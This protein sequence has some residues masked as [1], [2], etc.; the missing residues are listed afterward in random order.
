VE[1]DGSLEPDDPN[2][3][4]L[5]FVSPPL[6]IDEILGDLNKV[7]KWAKEYGCYTNDSTGLHINISVP[8]YSRENLDFVKLALLMGDKY[9]LD[10]FGRSGNTYAKSALDIVKRAVRDNP[11]NAAQL[12]DKMKGNLDQLASKAIHSGITSKYTSINTKDGH[13]EF[14]SPGG[15]WLGDNFDQIENTL[16]RFTVA[17][18][19]ALNP[20]MYRQ[21]YLTKLY[22]MLTENN[23]DDDTIKYFSDY[24]AGKIPKAALRSFVKQAQL[25]RNIKRGKTDGQKM[26]WKVY[27][28][29]KNAGRYSATV[30]VVAT[31]EKEAIEKAAKEW[32]EPLLVNTLARMD[33]EPLRPYVEQPGGGTYELFDR[34]TNETI[35]DTEFSSRNDADV[36][37]RL[38]DYINHGQHGMSTVD[39]RLLFSARPVADSGGADQ[40][41]ASNPLRPTGP[42]PWEVYNRQTGNSTVNLIRDGQPITD[43]AQAQ[44]QAM[45]LISTGRHDLYG[46]RTRGAS[47]MSNIGTQTD[48]ENRLGL[49]SQSTNANYAVVDRRTLDPVFRFSAGNRRDANRIYGEWLAAAGLPT[50]TEDY[51]FQE[52][53]PRSGGQDATEIPRDWRI[54]DRATDETLNT[55]R[56]ASLDQAEAVRDDTA[57]RHGVDARQ[58]SLQVIFNPV[59]AQQEIPEVPM[60]VAQNFPDRTDGRNINFGN[61]FSGQWRVM[62]DGEEVW[63]FRGVGNNQADANRIAQTWLQDQRSQGSLSPGDNAEIEVVPVMIESVQESL[64]EIAAMPAHQFAGGKDMLGMFQTPAK[65][66]LKP[67]PGGTDLQ[68]AIVKG[69]HFYGT[70]VQIVDPGMPGIT[71]PQVV[72]VL[73]LDSSSLPNTMQVG[74]ITVD[75]DYRGRGLARAL[76][77]IVLTI[78]Q[79]NL[80][81]GSS[82]TPGG[83][84]NWM[85]LAS[86][87]GVEV[88]GL[89]RIPNQIFDLERTATASPQWR[90]YADRTMDQI[91]ELGGQFHSKDNNSTYWLFDVVPGKGSLQPAVKNALSRLYGYDSDNLLLATWTGA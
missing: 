4:G 67:L 78:M 7:K 83:R 16:L 73:N 74:S 60:D 46:V 6:P 44:S 21:E 62:L 61:Q 89:V 86:I 11:D 51:G 80:V 25:Q 82:Q 48:M 38:D 69:T 14:R 12:L 63:R 42:G 45:A 88:Q 36:Q 17:M 30:E 28:D 50:T 8:G 79:K 90:K 87:P 68:Y 54:V 40:D 9:V 19:A 29:G 53:R 81:S 2:D 3:Q 33:A 35:P 23:R 27:K 47:G 41:A 43:R 85:S 72:A 32:G 5:E 71:R 76:Y 13:I 56:G 34:R 84:R 91:M 70:I 58:L 57:R 22:K 37:T 31:S 10:A 18:S 15:D 75:E 59:A 55:V 26:W 39:A 49:P 65:K 77:G 24:V 66:H 1:P 52:I 64:T 20:E